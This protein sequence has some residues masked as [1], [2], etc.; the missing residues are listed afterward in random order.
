MCSHTCWRRTPS[1]HGRPWSC[2]G[3]MVRK[4]VSPVVVFALA[5]AACVGRVESRT[6]LQG[7][8][9]SPN[10]ADAGHATHLD[11]GHSSHPTGPCNGSWQ[12]C[13]TSEGED[14][15]A[16]CNGGRT[17]S[18]CGLLD[19]LN[20][21]HP[22]DLQG[23]GPQD[24]PAA[25]TLD[26][27]GGTWHFAA[28]DATP[29][30]LAFESEAVRFT[31]AVGDFDLM[32]WEASVGTD[33]VGSETPW[34]ALDRD[35]NRSIDDGRELF[36]SMTPLSDGQRAPNGFAALAALDD[37]GDG[38][39][40]PRDASFGRLLVWRDTNQDRRS[41]PGELTRAEDAGL[42]SIE[43]AYRVVPRCTGDNCEIERAHFVFREGGSERVGDV[44]DV[45]LAKR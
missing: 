6:D 38:R 15:I 40:T 3:R 9:L 45:H 39:I 44:V 13:V 7:A 22:G 17:T 36:G 26:A 42:V 30:V 25:C 19:A 14:G 32:G 2:G 16:T 21:C 41:E 8:E 11:A 1:L 34:L 33:W 31:R 18:A 12:T 10:A 29:L 20:P 37:D 28:C 23:C 24:P 35:G 5:T 43:L 27:N 4:S